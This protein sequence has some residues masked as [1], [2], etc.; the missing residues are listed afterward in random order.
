MYEQFFG[1]SR[2]PFRLDPEPD[3]F[4][5]GENQNRVLKCISSALNSNKG[6][7]TLSGLPGTGKTTVIIKAVEATITSGTI[8]TRINRANTNNLLTSISGELNQ[9]LNTPD[10]NNLEALI[11]KASMENRHI[12]ILVDEAQQ[13]T[14]DEINTIYEIIAKDDNF[15]N[16]FK[17]L[18]I[19][20]EDLN[21]HFNL[22]QINEKS[23]MLSEHC[24]MLPLRENELS[25]Y[26]EHRLKNAGWNGNPE[27]DSSIFSI[28]FKITKGVPRRVNSFFDRFLL[29]L[30]MESETR[31][32]LDVVK[33][34][35]QDLSNELENDPHPDL[36]SSDL[37]KAL[38]LEKKEF[39]R[40]QT[41]TVESQEEPK[42]E[43]PSKPSTIKKSDKELAPPK[44]SLVKTTNKASTE[45]EKP[46]AQPKRNL[47]SEQEKQG[48]LILMV[49]NYLENPERFKHYTDEFYKLPDDIEILLQL[50][51]EKDINI[52]KAL[53]NQLLNVV[54]LEV[55]RMIRH[56]LKRVLF[57]TSS[58]PYR[59]LGLQS[60]ASEKQINRHF[61]YLMRIC[62]S[63]VGGPSEWTKNEE[64]TIKQAYIKILGS[65]S[66]E[67]KQPV[68]LS[69]V[70]N[71]INTPKNHT[72]ENS[73]I[74]ENQ[75]D[76]SYSSREIQDT[77]NKIPVITTSVIVSPP[78]LSVSNNSVIQKS[79]KTTV[80]IGNVNADSA[81]LDTTNSENTNEHPFHLEKVQTKSIP[82]IPVATVFCII[83]AIAITVLLSG[84]YNESVDNNIKPIQQASIKKTDVAELKLLNQHDNE[85]SNTPDKAPEVNSE[86]RVSKILSESNKKEPKPIIKP[87]EPQKQ[88]VIKN[89]P[90]PVKKVDT[91]KVDS[92]PTS[93]SK[94]TSTKK[95]PQPIAEKKITSAPAIEEP[96]KKIISA[97]QIATPSTKNETIAAKEP[98][99]IAITKPKQPAPTTSTPEPKVDP[100][101]DSISELTDA[102]LNRLIFY[103]KR[104]YESGDIDIFGGLF[105][106]DAITNESENRLQ[107]VRDYDALFNVTNKRSIQLKN[108]S[109]AK[110][111]VVASGNGT[112][113]LSIVEKE[114]MAPEEIR[115]EIN[116][117]AEKIDHKAQ[118]RELFYRYSF[119]AN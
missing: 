114:G 119:T 52:E 108:L 83:G 73:S 113:V 7:I 34:F 84:G 117:K 38:R 39:E 93:I 33:E 70:P 26:I 36:D 68:T 4:Y 42:I 86:S 60:T 18:L 88:E 56:F 55:R 115:G 87:E 105:T 97:K 24:H 17:F 74:T 104:S 102:D 61:D 31:A 45:T 14:S 37:Q 67:A 29:H 54:P 110:D 101:S 50:A 47:T 23:D 89:D 35:C 1:L 96:N 82:W 118:I 49:S 92:Q 44:I 77:S 27:L 94:D 106:D 59:V 76:T 51:I 116:I 12:L 20:H 22:S 16:Y 91:K 43:E 71:H 63:D 10:S 75:K 112:F 21:E 25:Q 62:R 6:V 40:T 109:W 19:G 46:K 100:P 98:I 69:A 81:D 48:K 2:T 65:N 30:F 28:I 79:E 58:D 57:P 85:A 8:V 80:K 32:D 53:P 41:K 5:A 90:L 99:P 64:H 11:R 72:A 78:E 9:R 13:I 103:F 66:R 107:I 111:G 95:T 3:M 15:S